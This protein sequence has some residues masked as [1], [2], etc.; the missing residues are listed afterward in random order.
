M[1][2][3]I[4]LESVSLTSNAS[5]V[6]FDDSGAGLPQEYS[7]LQLRIYAHSDVTGFTATSVRFRINALTTSYYYIP[8]QYGNNT[9]SNN[10]IQNY[11]YIELGSIGND[12][13]GLWPGTITADIYNYSNTNYTTIVSRYANITGASSGGADMRISLARTTA[14]VTKLEIYPSSGNFEAGSVFS[15]YGWAD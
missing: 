6:I 15:L 7:G 5:S 13:Q 11:P 14:V 2:G 12:N 8:Y 3:L 1:A 10:G 9:Y 4:P